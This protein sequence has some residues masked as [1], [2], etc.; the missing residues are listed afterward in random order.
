MSSVSAVRVVDSR[1][2]WAL[3]VEIWD[4]VWE[5]S[6][7]REGRA[8]LVVGVVEGRDGRVSLRYA[9]AEKVEFVKGERRGSVL[10]EVDDIEWGLGIDWIIWSKL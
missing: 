5:V 4:C 6:D 3:R 9:V 8:D 7:A 1:A 2:V 10:S